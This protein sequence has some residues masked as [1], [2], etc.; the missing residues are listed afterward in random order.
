MK[1]TLPLIAL[2]FVILFSCSEKG[3]NSE[4]RTFANDFIEVGQV[5]LDIDSISDFNFP[6]FQVIQEGEEEL[7]L[8][9]NK[10]NFSF[11]FYDLES[12]EKVKRTAIQK[13]EKYPIPALYGFWYHNADSI[14]LFRQMFLNGITLLD[15]EGVIVTQYNPQKFDRRNIDEIRKSM[16]NHYSRATNPTLYENGKLYFSDMS[17][18]GFLS[19]SDVMEEFR[20]AV[21]VDIINNIASKVDEIRV[22]FFYKGKVW[23]MNLGDYS[24]IIIGNEMIYSWAGLDSLVI[25][26][27]R[28]KA[29][30]QVNTQSE[31]AHEL[32]F[33][34]VPRTFTSGEVYD[35]ETLIK[36]RVSQTTYSYIFYDPYREL[37]Y[38][39]VNIGRDMDETDLEDQFPHLK[40][41]FS[42]IVLDKDFNV[43]T[44]K[45]FPGKIHYP[46][47]S[48]VGKKGLYLSRTNPFYDGL[49]EDE[50]VYDVLEFK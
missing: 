36:E 30:K 34:N 23:P 28:S 40:N 5:K 27:K 10:V 2:A 1:H 38:R 13:D 42:I 29:L 46:Y 9:M 25:F 7:L 45:R 14:F 31:Y 15:K 21:T 33:T 43:L 48:F 26:D 49:N 32:K 47:K 3:S 8:V 39:F 6:E 11:D 44:E 17:S 19:S 20:P 12:G 35:K 41:D 22:P 16:V 18:N 24:R 4:K 37:Y 50:V